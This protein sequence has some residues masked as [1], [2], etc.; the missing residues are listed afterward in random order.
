MLSEELQNEIIKFRDKRNWSQY[1]TPKNLAISLSLEANELL[2]I[3]QW[4]DS[5][6]AVKNYESEIKD[7]LADIIIYFVLMADR[8]GLDIEEIVAKKL[9]KN[10]LKYPVDKSFGANTKYTEL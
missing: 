2:E 8:L 7:E 1:H 3:F 4:I 9:E 10:S 5:D 6:E